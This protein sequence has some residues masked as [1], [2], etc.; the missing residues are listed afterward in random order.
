MPRLIFETKSLILSFYFYLLY[1]L[2][3]DHSFETQQRQS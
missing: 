2:E 1:L 3:N